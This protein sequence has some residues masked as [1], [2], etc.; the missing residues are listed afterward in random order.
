MNLILTR[1]FYEQLIKCTFTNFSEPNA[2]LYRSWWLMYYMQVL[3]TSC[4]QIDT[5][6]NTDLLYHII[7]QRSHNI[8]LFQWDCNNE[9][10][11]SIKFKVLPKNVII[12]SLCCMINTT[13]TSSHFLEQF[14]FY[15]T[16]MQQTQMGRAESVF[17]KDTKPD[18]LTCHILTK[19]R[20]VSQVVHLVHLCSICLIF[21]FASMKSSL[22]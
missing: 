6:I 13:F 5:D 8:A 1:Q 21:S 9:L 10:I 22:Q 19:V 2:T 18:V 14:T 7:T 16:Y 20:L 11:N 4:W 3:L 17:W 12:D 15:S